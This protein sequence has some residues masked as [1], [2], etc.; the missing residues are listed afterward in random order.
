MAGEPQERKRVLGFP[1]GP[2]P[3][4]H[5][6]RQMQRLP[7]TPGDWIGPVDLQWFRSFVHPVRSWKRWSRHRRLGPYAV[8]DDAAEPEGRQA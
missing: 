2:D 3:Y 8:D 1:T 5:G 7:A 6:D 4:G